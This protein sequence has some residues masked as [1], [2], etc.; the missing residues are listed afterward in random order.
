MRHLIWRRFRR[1]PG[2]IVGCIVL[3]CI[4]LA[5]AF[6][7]LSP[8]DP[9]KSDMSIRYQPPSLAHPMGT[10]ALGRDCD[11]T[12]ACMADGYR[13]LVGFSVMV[14]TLYDRRTGR[15]DRRLF[16]RQGR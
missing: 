13:S 7:G 6:A 4:I 16:W 9:E 2:A 3:G 10:D 11:D 12:G 1:H 5:V 8:Y 14:I 15:G